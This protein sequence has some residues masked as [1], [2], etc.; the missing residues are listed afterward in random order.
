[1]SEQ[2]SHRT[3]E[4]LRAMILSWAK[5]LRDSSHLSFTAFRIADEMEKEGRQQ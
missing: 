3:V 1:L 2:H 4:E 5:Q